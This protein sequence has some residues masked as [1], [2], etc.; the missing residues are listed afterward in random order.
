MIPKYRLD[1]LVRQVEQLTGMNERLLAFIPR[2]DAVPVAEPDAEAQR[3]AT[4][5]QELAE[6]DPKLA[7]A[8]DLGASADKILAAIERLESQEK[9]TQVEWD[10]HAKRMLG[11][12]HDAFAKA[13]SGDKKLGKDLPEET[14]QTLTDNFIT[15]V[16]KDPQR[17]ARYNAKDQSLQGDFLTAWKQTWV[18]PWRRQQV[19]GD[20]RQARRVQSLPV[21]GGTASPMGTP[22]PKPTDSDD[23]DEI[24][25]RAFRDSMARMENSS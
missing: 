10:S 20:V 7:R 14:R 25:R 4:L 15:W 8:M 12:I 23:E 9:Q 19:A 1:E 3:K 17:T 2:P 22:A 6:L 5:V 16:L 18:E 24:Y 21:S 13:V 11:S